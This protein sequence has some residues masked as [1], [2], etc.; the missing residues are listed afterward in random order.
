MDPQGAVYLDRI[1][2][3]NR[4]TEMWAWI[5][6]DEQGNEGL[7]AMMTEQ[8]FQPMV[9][10]DPRRRDTLREVAEGEMAAYAAAHGQRIEER[11]YTLEVAE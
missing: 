5:A 6:V 11:R 9:A 1:G 10:T 4:I 3:S 7:A 2:R 8:G